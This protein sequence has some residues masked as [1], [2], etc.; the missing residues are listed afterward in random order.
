MT[1]ILMVFAWYGLGSSS[2]ALATSV[3]FN[4]EQACNDALDRTIK[5]IDGYSSSVRAY[6][7]PKG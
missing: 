3:E 5:E 1:Y 6:C 7:V 2:T 4:T